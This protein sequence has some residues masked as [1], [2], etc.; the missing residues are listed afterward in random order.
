VNRRQ[1]RT[2]E[3]IFKIP[4]PANVKWNDLI[5]LLNGL[6]ARVV[7]AEGSRVRALFDDTEIVLHKPHPGDELKRYV[8]RQL[9]EKFRSMGITP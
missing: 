4:P 9:R 1:R 6:G 3:A 2:L 8:V 5:G 7:E